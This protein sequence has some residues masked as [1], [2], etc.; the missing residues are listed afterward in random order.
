MVK[1]TDIKIQLFSD[2]D[3]V[4]ADFDRGVK[5]V[6][7]KLPSQMSRSEMWGKISDKKILTNS[8]HHA[9]LSVIANKETLNKDLRQRTRAIRL[10]DNMG[11]L[12]QKHMTITNK[13][14]QVLFELDS[15]KDYV[16]KIDFYNNL[17]WMPDGKVLWNY[18]SKYEPIINT[19][20]PMGEW[21]E[22]QKRSWISRELGPDVPVLVGMARDKASNAMKF[23]RKKDLEGSIIIDDRPKHQHIWE[24]AGGIW[25]THTDT[26]STI[27]VLKEMDL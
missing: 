24:N 26:D 11:L 6:T 4:L 13:G 9:I 10:L 3:G 16:S 23:L 22:P 27:S 5:K 7:G 17:D 12:D 18:I 20:L 25:I 19:G 1:T 2:L 21:A 14:F 8:P 15:G